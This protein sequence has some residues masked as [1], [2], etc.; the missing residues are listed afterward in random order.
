MATAPSTLNIPVRYYASDPEQSPG[1]GKRSLPHGASR[2]ALST[3]GA[4]SVELGTGH[5]TRG[6][7]SAL[8]GAFQGRIQPSAG[9]LAV[10]AAGKA[11]TVEADGRFVVDLPMRRGENKIDLFAVFKDHPRGSEQIIVQSNQGQFEVTRQKRTF[12]LLIGK[13]NYGEESGYAS[14]KTP[15]KDI[16]V[17]GE[18]L[19]TK[20]GMLTQVEVGA[21]A[22][23]SL[24]LKDVGRDE[25]YQAMGL[26]ARTADPEDSI[27]VYYAGHGSRAQL[28]DGGKIA[29]WVPSKYRKDSEGADLISASEL[30]TLIRR[31][32]ARHVLLI[33][34]SCYSGVLAETRGETKATLESEQ[35]DRYLSEM[36]RL[37]SRFLMSSG[38]DEPLADE[39]G[40]GLS[41]FAR[42]LV[43][44]LS[45][46]MSSI[47]T[48]EQLFHGRVRQTV[49]GKSQQVPQLQV[50]RDSGH[51]NGNFTFFA[52]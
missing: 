39:G 6:A 3:T 35:R 47:F 38:G 8:S 2:S 23:K 36:S 4:V 50:I 10:I 41:V 29:N 24:V 45:T 17:L 22:S 16:E 5:Q 32:R 9:L 34:D 52:R 18:M 13:Q 1:A 14:L 21:G 20:Y 48:V 15:H 37:K 12:A 30:N 44:G 28:P 11:A 42:A 40:E 19:R 33:A 46:P 27:L 25:I 31:M 7:S 43:Q 26:L 51:E 49:A